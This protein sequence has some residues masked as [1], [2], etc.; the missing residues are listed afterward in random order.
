MIVFCTFINFLVL[1]MLSTS[2]MFR[3]VLRFK[4]APPRSVVREQLEMADFCDLLA[5]SMDSG[6]N[7][8]KAF[9]SA[10]VALVSQH[11]RAFAKGVR[12]QVFCGVPVGVAMRKSARSEL[13]SM[14][15][16]LIQAVDLAASMGNGLALAARKLSG[17][18]RNRAASTLEERAARMPVLMLFPLA[19][20]I[21]PVVLVLLTAG[22]VAEF[23][24]TLM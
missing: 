12:A 1:W 15:T 5:L 11:G 9:E 8:M 24:K 21:L 4:L 10:G 16:E 14:G 2:E 18:L 23:L 20:F 17:E 7:F 3:N 6:A 22:S 19:V 13:Y